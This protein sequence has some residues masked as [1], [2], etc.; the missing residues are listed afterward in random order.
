MSTNFYVTGGTMRLDAP[1]YIKRQADD[2]LYHA[3]QQGE[4]CSILDSSQMGKSSLV[5]RVM[6]RLKQEGIK[7]IYFSLQDFGTTAV[8]LDNWYGSLLTKIDKELE[9]PTTASSFWD[10]QRQQNLTPTYCWGEVVRQIILGHCFQPIVFFLDEIGMV[11]SLPAF[12]DDFLLSLREFYNAR[13]TYPDFRRLT[14]CLIGTATPASL[15]KDRHLPP[16][17]VGQRIVLAD[18]TETEVTSSLADGLQ[19]KGTTAITLLQ[20]IWYW[21]NGHPYLTQKFCEAV[22]NDTAVTTA[23]GVDKVCQALFLASGRNKEANLAQVEDLVKHD[24]DVPGLLELYRQIRQQQVPDDDTQEKINALRLTGIITVRDNA[25]WVRNPIY[26][27][28]FDKVWIEANLP[29]A[30]KRRQRAAY[31]RG[32]IRASVAAT[33]IIAAIGGGIYWYFDGY[34]WENETYCN[35]FVKRYGLPQCIGELTTNQVQGRAVSYRLLRKGSKNPVY[36]VQAVRGIDRQ[37]AKQSSTEGLAQISD[38]AALTRRHG[39]STYFGSVSR[40]GDPPNQGTQESQWE[41]IVDTGGR[42]VYEK[43]FDE[44]NKLVWGLVYSP[45]LEG[46]LD[47][48]HYVGAEGF[49]KP[50]QGTTAEF[51]EFEYSGNGY[52][53]NLRYFDR[54]H[55]PQLG[56]NNAFLIQQQVNA[57][58]L[59][60]EQIFSDIHEQSVY[61]LVSRYDVLGNVTEQAFFGI[62]GQPLR[63]EE[64]FHKW[65]ARYD[66]LGNEIERAYFGTDGKP[67]LLEKEGVHKIF[68]QYDARGNIIEGAIFGTD[69]KPILNKNGVHK[70]TAKFDARGNEIE[71]SFFD[72]QGQPVLT[73]NA[74]HK[75][76]SRYNDRGYRIEEA[77]FDTQGQ[78]IFGK[79]T[80]YHKVVIR[81]DEQGNLI[82][83]ALFNNQNQPMLVKESGFH[84]MV[85]R[86]DNRGNRI[87][88]AFF[89]IQGQPILNKKIGAHKQV[90][91]Y[92]ERGNVFERDYLDIFGNLTKKKDGNDFKLLEEAYFD[93]AGKPISDENGVHKVVRHFHI[94]SFGLS[95]MEE[96][97][98]DTQ[99]Q[100]TFYKQTGL[101]KIS[102]HYDDQFNEVRINSFDIFGNLVFKQDLRGKV[103]EATCFDEAGKPS[104]FSETGVHK[105]VTRHDERDNIVE[106]TAFDAQGQ[107]AIIKG[108]HHK[109]VSRFDKQN[110]EIERMFF[111]TDGQKILL[112]SG[113]HKW[114]SQ[115]DAQGNQTERTY[116][117]TEGNPL[118]MKVIVISVFPDSQGE[119][120]GIQVGDIF[121]HYDGKPIT[122][123][124]SFIAGRTAE[125]AD[126]PAKELKVLRDGKELTFMVKPEKIGVELQDRAES[127]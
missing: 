47:R 103:N 35:Q 81:Y 62:D 95:E 71:K 11:Q 23:E 91:H 99:G 24:P 77:Y 89:D 21:T 111:G 14:F 56:P 122:D 68:T 113:Y 63:P 97:I 7:V 76:V 48:A 34:V 45:R 15:I 61:K 13:T 29:D 10:N 51:V 1:S 67:V 126:G 96:T 82:E 65:I 120:L 118:T 55:Q 108:G 52:E 83:T 93:E 124:T 19:H 114:S 8:T 80:G 57:Q 125:P 107:P 85:M 9:L 86:Y 50:Q 75:V 112:E 42:I 39:I 25:L 115:F 37:L 17:N 127:K 66:V 79:K 109:W 33:G 90:F 46:Q 73:A 87:E 102:T 36:K 22:A 94:D 38:I 53:K 28:V 44:R 100:P 106:G 78:P 70:W 2:E 27:Q 18:F 123:M 58:G 40:D 6:E 74:Y 72:I 49:P 4:Y 104:V 5:I 43:A 69:G 101:H 32:L 92:D 3:L 59:V 88:T 54:Q 12:T 121:T 116:F 98:F 64:G 117:D 41:F 26:L 30:E 20:R 105:I 31:R 16:F 84:K 60:T 119:K 110:H